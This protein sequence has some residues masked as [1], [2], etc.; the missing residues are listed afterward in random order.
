LSRHL[1]LTS[2][3]TRFDL[4]QGVELIRVPSTYATETNP[5]WYI[6]HG[7]DYILHRYMGWVRYDAVGDGNFLFPDANT[8]FWFYM[9]GACGVYERY[10]KDAEQ[11]EGLAAEA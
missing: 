6:T 7:I 2:M 1:D 5:R 3:A 8:A 10:W 4:G 9:K 11:Q